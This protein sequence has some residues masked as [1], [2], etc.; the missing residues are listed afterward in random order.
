MNSKKYLRR[1]KSVRKKCRSELSSDDWTKENYYD[2]C[3]LSID[4]LPDNI[5]R[6]DSNQVSLE[7]FIEKY[8]KQYKPCIILNAQKDWNAP[9]K[10]T[11][12]V[13]TEIEYITCK[14]FV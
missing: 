9:E 10:W 3:D 6:I 11:L 5:D 8:E 14:A 1:I 4:Y 12:E 2:K 7:E 13:I